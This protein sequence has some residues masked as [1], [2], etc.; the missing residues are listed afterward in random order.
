MNFTKEDLIKLVAK[1]LQKDAQELTDTL[2]DVETNEEL[3]EIL[4]GTAQDRIKQIRK[5]AKDQAYGRAKREEY[6]AAEKLIIEK[7]GIEKGESLEDM[8]ESYLAAKGS[9]ETANK[10]NNLTLDDMLKSEAMK[11][12][13]GKFR[14]Q[15]EELSKSLEAEKEARSLDQ[16][17]FGFDSQLRSALKRANAN[18]GEGDAANTQYEMYKMYLTNKHKFNNE[19]SP[20]DQNGDPVYSKNG[21]DAMTLDDLVKS[22]WTFGFKDSNNNQKQNRTPN[23]NENNFNKT[24]FG[25]KEEDLKDG[26]LLYEKW[27]EA[28]KAG[29]KD[30]TE[31]YHK[32]LIESAK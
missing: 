11:A 23:P 16:F 25:L 4:T 15:I 1:L 8:L 17:N 19:Y 5:N 27:Q 13:I 2:Q 22:T 30:A 20:I 31:Y 3:E 26:K 6:S 29:N 9:K 10:K 28:K 32:Q 12:H 21:Y 7:L 18:L 24:Q 14:K